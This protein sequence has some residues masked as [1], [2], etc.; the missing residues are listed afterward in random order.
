[1]SI[2]ACGRSC[3]IRALVLAATSAAL[4]VAPGASATALFEHSFVSS[5]TGSNFIK[6][7]DTIS[8]ESFITIAA[9]TPVSSVSLDYTGDIDTALATEHPCEPDRDPCFAATANYVSGWEYASTASTRFESIG[10]ARVL[11]PSRELWIDSQVDGVGIGDPVFLAFSALMGNLELGSFY[12]GTGQQSL[13]GT[14][15]VTAT[16][17]G[18]F[19]AGALI[20]P[21]VTGVYNAVSRTGAGSEIGDI[22]S[23]VM[24]MSFI[25]GGFTVLTTPVPEPSTALLV[26]SGLVGVC[27]SARGRRKTPR[28][29][30]VD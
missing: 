19:N 15:T 5:S 6:V 1:M 3:A 26:A 9:G 4:L 13:I 27:V 8:F 24:P 30:C 11:G 7:G 10:V 17:A 2:E 12:E 29:E 21:G 20:Y 25:A 28:S 16:H 14:V 18:Q 23:T 22:E